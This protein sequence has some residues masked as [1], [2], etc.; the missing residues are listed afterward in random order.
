MS[1]QLSSY[2]ESH[3]LLHSHQGAYCP[4]KSTEDILLVAVDTIVHHPDKGESV[5]AAFLDLHKAFD[6]L[7]HC[8]LLHNLSNLGVSTSVLRW[9]QNYLSDRVHHVKSGHQFSPWVA[10]RGGIPQGS[11]LGPLL[12]LIYMN[13]LPSSG[14]SLLLQYADD[15]TLVCSISTS[16]PAARIMNQQ[17]A[18]ICDWLIR[19]RMKLNVRKSSFTIKDRK[20]SSFIHASLSM[21]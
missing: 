11:A 6:S 17:L 15:T 5:C 10:M 18:L 13:T 8:I 9:F 16:A 1:A 2:L 4:G 12:F 3:Q 19:H 21:M 14:S 7:D 20:S